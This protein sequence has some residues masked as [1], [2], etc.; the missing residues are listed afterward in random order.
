MSIPNNNPLSAP[1]NYTQYLAN[2]DDRKAFLAGCRAMIDIYSTS[3]PDDLAFFPYDKSDERLISLLLHQHRHNLKLQRQDADNIIQNGKPNRATLRAMV[4]N[5]SHINDAGYAT[6]DCGC[7]IEDGGFQLV[8]GKEYRPWPYTLARHKQTGAEISREEYDALPPEQ[9]ENYDILRYLDIESD[10][11]LLKRVTEDNE[12]YMAELIAYDIIGHDQVVY[13]YLSECGAGHGTLPR[14]R[15]YDYRETIANVAQS[16]GII[17]EMM[18]KQITAG[19]VNSLGQ[20]YLAW[21]QS[22]KVTLTANG[23]CNMEPYQLATLKLLLT[24]NQDDLAYS[25]TDDDIMYYRDVNGN[26]MKGAIA[27]DVDDQDFVDWKP[28]PASD[29]RCDIYAQINYICDVLIPD[30]GDMIIEI[31]TRVDDDMAAD[32]KYPAMSELIALIET[33]EPDYFEDEDPEPDCIG[34]KGCDGDPN[35]RKDKNPDAEDGEP[36]EEGSEKPEPVGDGG[37]PDGEE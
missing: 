1:T 36:P 19:Y 3:S 7:V 37:E 11:V 31:F 14:G 24:A 25:A 12:V 20:L 5:V 23:L 26:G 35:V 6:D 8:P 15:F 32:M 22:L 28:I 16:L 33:I 18:A 29:E 4:F 2:P 30:V 13:R 27:P 21:L 34:C 9:Q 10:G 17:N